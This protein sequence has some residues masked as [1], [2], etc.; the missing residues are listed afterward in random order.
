MKH[1]EVMPL[2]KKEDPLN[3]ENYWPVNQLPHLSKYF[4][5]M[6]TKLVAYDTVW[7][8]K[9][10]EFCCVIYTFNIGSMQTS[11]A[12]DVLTIMKY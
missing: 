5:R 9:V 6:R 4:E 12:L 1:L 11:W 8:H 7:G 10:G 2:F 3:K